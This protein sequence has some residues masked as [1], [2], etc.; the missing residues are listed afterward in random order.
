MAN[1][2]ENVTITL[3]AQEASIIVSV[4]G[5]LPTSSGAWPLLQKVTQQVKVQLD[6]REHD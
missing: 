1:A 6:V 4:L 3:T 5:Q 2:L